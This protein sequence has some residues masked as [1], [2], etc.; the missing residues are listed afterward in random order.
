MCWVSSPTGPD[1]A[2]GSRQNHWGIWDSLC[3]GLALPANLTPHRP[4]ASTEVLQGTS[5]SFQGVK[6]PAL[7]KE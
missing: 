1:G 4:V 7:R 6:V 2:K 5:C 3:P